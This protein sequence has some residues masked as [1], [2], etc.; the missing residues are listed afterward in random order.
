[1]FFILTNKM[2]FVFFYQTLKDFS[3]TVFFLLVWMRQRSVI[4]NQKIRLAMERRR[5]WEA[6][7]VGLH[8]VLVLQLPPLVV[9]VA[10][11]AAIIVVDEDVVCPHPHLWSMLLLQL[12]WNSSGDLV[13]LTR[14]IETQKSGDEGKFVF[15][16]AVWFCWVVPAIAAFENIVAFAV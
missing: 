4:F 16:F 8:P 3:A 14:L 12:P 10:V 6:I 13:L 7:Q 11:A 2:L 1:M 5:N 9:V 15:H